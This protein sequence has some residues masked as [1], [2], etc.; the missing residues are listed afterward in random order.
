MVAGWLIGSNL[1]FAALSGS[2]NEKQIILRLKPE[3]EVTVESGGQV[4][5]AKPGAMV[6]IGQQ[7]YEEICHICHESGIGGA[8][9][10]GDKAEWAP[11]IAAGLEVLIKHAIQGYKTMP[12]KGTC[13]QCSD[14]EIKKSVEYMVSHSK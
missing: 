5:A 12:A 6:E 2:L 10:M 7:R 11:R 4:Q 13:M 14:E 1:S 8:P 9:K 3:G